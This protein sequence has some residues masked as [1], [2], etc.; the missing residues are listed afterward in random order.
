MVKLIK[1]SEALKR[2]DV[3]EKA[4]R[5][6]VPIPSD[7][8]LEGIKKGVQCGDLICVVH[9]KDGNT[10]SLALVTLYIDKYT[11]NRHLLVYAMYNSPRAT[12]ETVKELL[13]GI[14]TQAKQMCCLSVVAINK[15]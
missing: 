13:Q 4:V 3:V 5:E 7:N 8:A 10:T 9:L 11:A 2:W 6:C 15:I 1:P 12:E 14:N